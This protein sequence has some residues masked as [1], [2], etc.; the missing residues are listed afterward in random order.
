MFA[1]GEEDSSSDSIPLFG[2]ANQILFDD[3]MAGSETLIETE[4]SCYRFT[5]TDPTKRHGILSGGSLGLECC[6][7]T[8]I[9]SPSLRDNPVNDSFT[10]LRPGVRMVFH[11]RMPN[12]LKRLVTSRIT[13]VSIVD[14][15]LRDN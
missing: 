6:P 11:V 12:G 9:G 1:S 10:S 5:M 14:D 2:G 13:S 15:G 8:I 4:S 3:L 7:A